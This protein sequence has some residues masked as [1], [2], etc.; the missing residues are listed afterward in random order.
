ML[1]DLCKRLRDGE[2]FPGPSCA[3]IAG[4]CT[5]RS[6]VRFALAGD[7]TG[8]AIAVK[9]PGNAPGR[10]RSRRGIPTAL[11]R[12]APPHVDLSGELNHARRSYGLHAGVRYR[13]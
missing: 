2:T 1:S 10:A 13:W 12:D 3:Q 5:T 6:P 11:K 7:P 8:T 4:K 9:R